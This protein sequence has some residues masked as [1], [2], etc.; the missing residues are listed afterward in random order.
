MLSST[1]V[2][3]FVVVGF[4]VAGFFAPNFYLYQKAYER[5]EKIQ[6]ELPD[7][8]DLLTISVE[9]GLGFDAAVQQVAHNTAGPLADELS[10]MLREMQLGQGRATALRGLAARSNVPE[11]RAFVGAMVQAARYFILLWFIAAALNMYV[12]VSRAGYSVAQE[13]PI[14]LVVFGVPAGIAWLV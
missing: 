11:L 5:S 2:K 13:F 6:R 14:F 8:I 4:V 10:R 7:A 1:G 12:G 3:F 9:S